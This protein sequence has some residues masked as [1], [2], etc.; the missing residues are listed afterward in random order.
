RALGRR[1]EASFA[2]APSPEIPSYSPDTL[3]ALEGVLAPVI[4]PLAG[5]LIKRTAARTHDREELVELLRKSIGDVAADP[6]L[7][8]TLR[9]ALD[10]GAAARA[11]V[12]IQA[13]STPLP[14]GRTPVPTVPPAAAAPT[15]PAISAEK[16]ELATKTLLDLVGPIAKVMVK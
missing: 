12:P 11:K 5:P 15:M 4:G 8:R 7:L 2:Y 10:G 3:K 6:S 14:L 1:R 16:L 9:A 13:A